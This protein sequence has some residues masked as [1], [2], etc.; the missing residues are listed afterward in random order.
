MT[1]TRFLPTWVPI[2][3]LVLGGALAAGQ[4]GILA[5]DLAPGD[6]LKPLGENWPSSARWRKSTRRRSG[7]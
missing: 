2:S 1:L 5:R 3:A 6:L 4:T 7:S